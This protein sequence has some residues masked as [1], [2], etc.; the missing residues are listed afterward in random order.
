[1]HFCWRIY[2][3]LPLFI[4]ESTHLLSNRATVVA[5]IILVTAN[6]DEFGKYEG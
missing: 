3:L 5:H 4:H 2:A 6:E 1:M